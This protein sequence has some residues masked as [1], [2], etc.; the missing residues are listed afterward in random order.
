MIMA[1]QFDE[2]SFGEKATLARQ[3]DFFGMDVSRLDRV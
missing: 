2:R 1:L 3:R